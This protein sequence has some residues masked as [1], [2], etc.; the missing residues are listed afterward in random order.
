MSKLDE[1]TK[2]TA[3]I[4]QLRAQEQKLLDTRSKTAASYY[5]SGGRSVD[6]ARAC[7]ISATAVLAMLRREGLRGDK[8][9][10]RMS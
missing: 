2:I 9:G 6:I 8:S 10:K 1:L 3:E 5:L 7:E 4:K